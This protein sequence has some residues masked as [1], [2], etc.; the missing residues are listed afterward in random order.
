METLEYAATRCAASQRL[1]WP[2]EG[3]ECDGITSDCAGIPYAIQEAQ[4]ALALKYNE[5]PSLLP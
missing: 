4:V 2:R 1:K 5:S 3:A